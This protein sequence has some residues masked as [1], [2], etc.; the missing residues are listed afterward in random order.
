M[1]PITP[2][3]CETMWQKL[4]HDTDAEL[5]VA[6]DFPCEIVTDKT[7]ENILDDVKFVRGVIS[8]ALSLRSRENLK[9][10]QPLQTLYIITQ[11]GGTIHAFDAVICAECNVKRVECVPTN[12]KF[13]TPFLTV[14]FKRAGAVL[15]DR[16]QKLKETLTATDGVKM[17]DLVSQFQTGKVS[18]GEFS[19]LPADV[20]LISQRVKSEYVSIIDGDLTVVL[21]TTLNDA[22]VDECILREIV[23]AVQVERQ[24]ADLEITARISLSLRTDDVRTQGIIEQNRQ[25]IMDEVLAVALFT[26]ADKSFT[27]TFRAVQDIEGKTVEIAFAEVAK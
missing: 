7:S 10:R 12:D 5:V 6:A 20:F 1:T 24:T 15:R 9:L 8:L 18:I 4:R 13:N 17:A 26:A 14:N 11:K 3:M 23:R 16:A 22:L 21:D 25:K 19:D 27:D 2:F